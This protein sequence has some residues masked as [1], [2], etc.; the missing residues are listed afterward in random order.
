MANQVSGDSIGT[1]VAAC[2]IASGAG[3]VANSKNIN[4]ASA[5]N[6]GAGVTTITLGGG[7]INPADRIV[8]ACIEGATAGTIAI[9]QTSATVIGVRTF[10]A[11][12]AAANRAFSLKVYRR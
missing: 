11:L 1:L 9:V 8:R 10:S 3:L 5:V 2:R 12:G 6:G 4:I 7:G